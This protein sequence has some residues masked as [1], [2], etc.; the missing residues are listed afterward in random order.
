KI[1]E[2]QTEKHNIQM[3]EISSFLSISK[4]ALSQIIN[5]LEDK[6]LVERIFLRSDR[7]AT[8]VRFTQKGLAIFEKKKDFMTLAANYIVKEMGEADSE[9][10]IELLNKFYNIISSEKFSFEKGINK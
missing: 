7:R 4:P 2:D 9:K 10:F 3:N 8:Y 5:K 1:D 6:G